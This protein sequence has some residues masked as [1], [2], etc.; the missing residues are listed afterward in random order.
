[1]PIEWLTN[2]LSLTTKKL[3]GASYDTVWQS[4]DV[5]QVFGRHQASEPGIGWIRF[6][7]A[8][9]EKYGVQ[10]I[11]YRKWSAGQQPSEGELRQM[12]IIDF[13]ALGGATDSE[14]NPI[15]GFTELGPSDKTSASGI[16][17]YYFELVSALP[18]GSLNIDPITGD[19]V[20]P[21]PEDEFTD[22]DAAAAVD[23][24]RMQIALVIF[25]VLAVAAIVV[26]VVYFTAKDKGGGGEKGKKDS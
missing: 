6:D 17:S 20:D 11:S 23:Q 1:M 24:N 26:L 3:V 9:F 2:T 15:Q 4:D 25:G 21:T 10:W 22:D 13:E 5:A 16:R 8:L 14:G 18:V 19:Y 7:R 12:S